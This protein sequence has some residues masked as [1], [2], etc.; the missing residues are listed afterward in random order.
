MSRARTATG[1]A[2]SLTHLAEPRAREALVVD[3]HEA[4]A[5]R[6][7]GGEALVFLRDRFDMDAAIL[8]VD[9]VLGCG[10]VPAVGGRAGLAAAGAALQVRTRK[11]LRSAGART[12][13]GQ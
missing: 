13:P 3:G 8:P 12:K 2:R 9:K 10:V 1:G 4:G 7:V 11:D 5:R 6:S